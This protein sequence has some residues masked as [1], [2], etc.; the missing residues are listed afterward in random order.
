MDDKRQVDAIF[1]DYS[2]AFDH[3]SHYVLVEKLYSFA[4]DPYIIRVI[5]NVLSNRVQGVVTE[6]CTSSLTPVMSGIPQGNVF[7][8]LLFLLYINDVC[9]G[10]STKIH[11]FADDT[12]IYREIY[13]PEDH[14]ERMI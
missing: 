6:A 4:L 3:V 10:L 12:V 14:L 7:G 8:P 5:E 1:L 13:G 11:L 9:T 2:K